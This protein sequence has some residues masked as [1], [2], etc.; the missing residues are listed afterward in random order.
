MP[1]K[2]IIVNPKGVDAYSEFP[3]RD[4]FGRAC[5]EVMKEEGL[6]R[7]VINELDFEAV[8]QKYLAL[9]GNFVSS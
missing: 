2:K 6:A 4:K 1:V 8:K 3:S 9:G 7:N 5:D